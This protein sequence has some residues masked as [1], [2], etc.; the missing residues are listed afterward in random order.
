MDISWINRGYHSIISWIKNS[1]DSLIGDVQNNGVCLFRVWTKFVFFFIIFI[2]FLIN[3]RFLWPIQ[4]NT[5]SISPIYDQ[6]NSTLLY[7]QFSSSL[8][9]C[10]GLPNCLTEIIGIIGIFGAYCYFFDYIK[11]KGQNMLVKTELLEKQYSLFF[12]TLFISII[13]AVVFIFANVYGWLKTTSDQLISGELFFL[14]VVFAIAFFNALFVYLYNSQRIEGYYNKLMTR[15]QYSSEFAKNNFPLIF[16][17]LFF[18]SI[19]LPIFSIVSGYN[20]ISIFCMELFI[21]FIMFTLAIF[22]TRQTKRM[23]LELYNGNDRDNVFVLKTDPT[24]VEIVSSSNVI[25]KIP[26]ASILLMSEITINQPQPGSQIP[27]SFQQANQRIICHARK[28]N[29]IIFG[30]ACVLAFLVHNFVAGFFLKEI[31]LM[32]DPLVFIFV[33]GFAVCLLGLFLLAVNLTINLFG[34]PD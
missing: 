29:E 25:E 2:F 23:R 22:S 5:I 7:H 16:V 33:T 24:F 30:V 17:L 10:T 26:T 9:T 21:L 8:Y 32:G 14:I 34:N 27:D 18:I 6:L 13:V 19:E 31:S 4:I 20:L 11:D 1:Y 3:V 15:N 28:L 12:Y